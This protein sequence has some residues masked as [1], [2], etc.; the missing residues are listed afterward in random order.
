VPQTFPDN[1]EET[2]TNI[3]VDLEHMHLLYTKLP[4]PTVLY[5]HSDNIAWCNRSMLNLFWGVGTSEPSYRHSRDYFGTSIHDVLPVHL[6]EHI[7]EQNIKVRK[8]K[9]SQYETWQDDT[10]K[11]TVKWNVLR[12]PCGDYHVGVVLF[13]K[14]EQYLEKCDLALNLKESS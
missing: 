8:S 12:F 9:K 5:D 1:F 7:Q 3:E 4:V 13:P 14:N 11:G 6:A 2:L 10:M